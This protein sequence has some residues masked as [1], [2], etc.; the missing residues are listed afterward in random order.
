[1]MQGG[2]EASRSAANSGDV[3]PA[4][5]NAV[6]R[7]AS[8][9]DDAHLR[10]ILMFIDGGSPTQ[11]RKYVVRDPQA[12]EYEE[13]D[14]L[15][16]TQTAFPI[17]CGFDC[18]S[19]V[20]QLAGEHEHLTRASISKNHLS[21]H[22]LVDNSR[23]QITKP[24]YLEQ[25]MGGDDTGHIERYAAVCELQHTG[26]N[27]TQPSLRIVSLKCVRGKAVWAAWHV[28]QE[29]R[30]STK[31][32]LGLKPR[33]PRHVLPWAGRGDAAQLAVDIRERLIARRSP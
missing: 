32:S 28:T 4:G 12:Y 26:V 16:K 21:W 25:L 27:A 3:H 17:L 20:E 18:T 19:D 30:T 2:S 22:L 10:D 8:L 6:R 15:V 24:L 1:M 7:D 5:C 9:R 29:T 23:W 14:A 31:S 11:I 13:L 33:A